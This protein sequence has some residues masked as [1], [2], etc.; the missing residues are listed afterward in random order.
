M[1]VWN[2]YLQI[3]S[4]AEHFLDIYIKFQGGTGILIG[5]FQI[6]IAVVIPHRDIPCI[7][8]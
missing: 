1:M 3:S 8:F 7:H 2:M 6:T 5:K 4:M